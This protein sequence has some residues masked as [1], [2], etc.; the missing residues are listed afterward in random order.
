MLRRKEST[1]RLHRNGVGVTKEGQVIF[2]VTEF[3]GA[4]YPNLFEFADLLRTLG[5]EEALFLDGDL[6][7]MVW[8]RM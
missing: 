7:D 4:K 8:G 6:S 5:G 3:G 2:A 1:S